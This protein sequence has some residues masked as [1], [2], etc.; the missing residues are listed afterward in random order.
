[1]SKPRV[2]VI[3]LDGATL[4]LIQ[5]WAAGCLPNLARFLQE[6]S[7]GKLLSTIPPV[8]PAAWTSFMTGK[9]PGRHGVFDF[10]V[11]DFRGYG[12]RVAL[13]SSEPSLWSILSAQGR[14][15]CVINVPQTYPPEAVNGCLVTGLGTPSGCVYTYPPELTKTLQKQGYRVNSKATLLHDGPDA[16]IEDVYQVAEKT[17]DTALYLLNQTDWDFG[18][19]VLRLTDEIPHFFWHWMDDSHP[20]H[21]Q[22]DV[23]HR[24]A[25]LRCYQKADELVGRLVTAV[26]GR[27]T[28][29]LVMSDH[30]FGPLYKD[31]Y[32]NEWLRQQGFLTLRQYL[33]L[34]GFLTRFL[35]KAGLTRSRIGHVLARWG[36]DWLRGFLRDRFK[37]WGNF[38]PQDGNLHTAELVD[39]KRTR[40][41][42]VGYIGQIYVNLIGRDPQGTVAAGKE[43][44]LLREELGQ[45]LLEM[46]DP[47]DGEQVVDRVF[48]KEEVYNGQFLP[49][50]P[51]LIVL[52]RGLSYITRQSYEFATQHQVFSVPPTKETGGHR[53]EGVLLAIGDRIAQHI[54]VENARIEDLMPTILHLLE[55]EV[56]TDVD[57]HV[58]TE[59]LHL[60]STAYPVKYSDPN[61]RRDAVAGLTPE[62]EQSV[63]E[64][65]RDL[66][67]IS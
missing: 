17:T 6:G 52:M 10:T 31:V 32:L 8:S 13:R 2:L 46:V 37:T 19:V 22:S 55:C 30:G 26:E 40:A 15:V 63:L 7:Y 47:E 18:M 1:M 57:G 23:L 24:E 3:G 41:Y 50:A 9:N 49:E 36:L 43:Y 39:W 62:E 44:E 48:R 51:D 58:L 60:N 35:Q 45:R 67:Y 33:S 27:G 21:R 66:G 59:L 5:P 53:L 65:L 20:A 56:P 61:L 16:F 28:N 29:V 25:I 11:R 4:D 14:R 42:S 64:H 38:F 12:M 54:R 34:R